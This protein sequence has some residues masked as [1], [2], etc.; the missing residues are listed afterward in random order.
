MFK[1]GNIITKKA[2]E[3][4]SYLESIADELLSKYRRLDS[5]VSHAP[6]KGNYHEK[7]LRDVIRSYLPNTFSTGEGFIINKDSR[8]SSQLDILIVDNFDPR[9]FG[10][11]ENDFFIAT[12]FAIACFG[13]VKT[14]CAKKDF[15]ASFQKLVDA[16]M[17]IKD[18]PAIAT[19]FMFCYDAYASED[20]ISEWVQEAVRTMPKYD[21]TKQ[22]H[23]PDYVFCFKKNVFLQ[24]ETA[25]GGFRY[26]TVKFKKNIKTSY[27]KLLTMQNLF[28]CITNGCGRLRQSQGIKMPD[29]SMDKSI[30]ID[31]Q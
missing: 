4:Q 21:L 24:R 8:V 9:S 22:W 5:V 25:E 1:E 6:T 12:D 19:S 11:K 2:V 18:M 16:K 14:Y 15:I 23:Y 7:I 29:I 27:I 13:E 10:H 20:T 3:S 17:V 30:I 26:T 31:A 28:Q